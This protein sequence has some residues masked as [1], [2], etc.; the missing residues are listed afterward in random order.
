MGEGGRGGRGWEGVGGGG[1]GWEGVGGGG[2]RKRWEWEGV[3]DGGGG[4]WVGSQR[5]ATPAIR[6][7]TVVLCLQ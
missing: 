1:R 7:Q 6:T 3:G 4:G 5:R 2:G